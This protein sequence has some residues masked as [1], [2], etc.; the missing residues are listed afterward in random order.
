M[1]VPLSPQLPGFITCLVRLK[2]LVTM[3]PVLQ[4][5]AFRTHFP[6]VLLALYKLLRRYFLFG[7]RGFFLS[8]TTSLFVVFI[9]KKQVGSWKM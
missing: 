9:L 7:C 8:H 2:H 4:R 6:I 3:F 5:L 1:S